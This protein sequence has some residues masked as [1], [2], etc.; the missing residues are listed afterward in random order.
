MELDLKLK[1]ETLGDY[2]WE[3]IQDKPFLV[4]ARDDSSAY[5]ILLDDHYSV[6]DL[7]DALT[8]AQVTGVCFYGTPPTDDQFETYVFR[9]DNA[10]EDDDVVDYC[11]FSNVLKN[12]I[13][14]AMNSCG[15]RLNCPAAAA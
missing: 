11:F 14:S 10:D 5:F 13:E 6:N 2:E 1:L 15:F 3:E 7:I 12:D 9:T 4:Q 8:L